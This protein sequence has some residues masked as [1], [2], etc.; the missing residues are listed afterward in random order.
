MKNNKM[1]KIIISVVV[2]ALCFAAGFFIAKE[3]ASRKV[4]TDTDSSQTTNAAD[5]AQ[6]EEIGEAELAVDHSLY[7]YL[8]DSENI[9]GGK[10]TV[11]SAEYYYYCASLYD[12]LISYA[13]QYDYYYGEG[14]GLAM[15]GF[16]ITKPADEQKYDGEVEGIKDPT[17]ADYIEYTARKQMEAVKAIVEYAKLNGIELSEKEKQYIANNIESAR[18][19]IKE[20]YGQT[21]EEYLKS[22]YGPLMTEELFV[23]I[24]EEQY[25][26]NKVDEIKT[27]LYSDSYTDEM[28]EKIYEEKEKTYAVADLRVYIVVA[29]TALDDE[30]NEKIT[31]E[32]MAQAKKDAEQLAASVIDDTTFKEKASYYEQLEN[33]ADYE[34][35]LSDDSYT[36]V[37]AITYDNITAQLGSGELAEWVFEEGKKV[38]DTF[39]FEREDTGYGV[40]MISKTPH[41][42]ETTY[43]YSV[44]HILFEFTKDG[45]VDT[46][47]DAIIL[48]TNKYD[49]VIDIDV[50]PE[51]TKEPALYNKAQ[52]VLISYLEGERT[53]ESFAELAKQYSADGNAADGG[54]YSDVAE[55]YMVAEFEAWCLAEGRKPGDVGIVET[56]YGYHVMYAVD[57]KVATSWETT[58]RDAEANDDINTFLE[59][60]ADS[61]TCEIK[62]YS[63]LDIAKDLE[64]IANGLINFYKQALSAQT[65]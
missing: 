5:E 60:L 4:K 19:G 59:V 9:G 48:D 58:L 17:Y 47:A 18:E 29:K 27:K 42:P 35:L 51:T 30:G 44:R 63:E 38:G 55:D 56:T 21:I 34:K 1:V 43:T 45:N 33:N 2:F 28:L 14:T 11:D 46:N 23:R 52:D 31:N 54:I 50:K 22:T 49:T 36:L 8:K 16:D 57:K 65:A 40:C 32:T 6:S 12:Q 13:V 20:Q 41:K 39:V 62:N 10:I 24:T 61:Y 15:T 53:E 64:E 7:T 26:T 25:L 3:V 37:E